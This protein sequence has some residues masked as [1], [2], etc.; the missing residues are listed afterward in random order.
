MCYHLIHALKTMR[1]L[2]T[3]LQQVWLHFTVFDQCWLT[4]SIYQAQLTHT[5]VHYMQLHRIEW[6]S[7][8]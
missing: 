8:I 3:W 1:L 5:R 4:E 6:M 2:H 7:N